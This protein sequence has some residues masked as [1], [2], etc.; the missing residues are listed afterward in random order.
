MLNKHWLKIA[1]LFAFIL[2]FSKSQA[3][4]NGSFNGTKGYFVKGTLVDSI[5]L[6]PVKVG[7]I[8]L[9]NALDLK[10]ID[11]MLLDS[12][13]DFLL[14]IKL[15]GNYFIHAS[16][17]GY[18]A[19]KSE[20]FAISDSLPFQRLSSLLLN[21]FIQS[22]GSVNIEIDGPLI[23]NK[24][25]KLVYNAEK[26]ISSKGGNAADVLRKVPM[27]EVDGD[28]NVTMRGSQNIRVLINGKPSGMLASNVRDAVKMIPADIISR[29][30]VITSPS[31]K[32]DAEGTAG[33]INIITK[34]QKLM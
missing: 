27:V 28:G 4:N 8:E 26:D 6:K 7:S 5:T 23:E 17:P 9:V 21:T 24:I 13:G 34:Q 2:L 10:I 25:D 18:F 14:N 20:V 16:A 22:I 15:P 1:F 31:A 19:K 29:V 33:I 30:E 32:Y 12:T 11:G 3:Q